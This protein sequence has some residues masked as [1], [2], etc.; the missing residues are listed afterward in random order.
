MH[1]KGIIDYSEPKAINHKMIT[2]VHRKNEEFLSY[3]PKYS[4]RK[5]K[6]TV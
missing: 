6:K 2:K 4:L 3:E 5:V 1:T